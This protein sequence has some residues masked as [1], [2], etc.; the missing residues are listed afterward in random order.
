MSLDF[1][2]INP[3]L[4]FEKDRRYFDGL[5]VDEDV[6]RQNSPYVGIGYL[7]AIAKK[8]KIKARYI[9]MTHGVSL[10][11]VLDYIDKQKPS[12]IG[13][14]AF[15]TKIKSAGEIARK[16]KEKYPKV[17]VCIGGSHAT[18]MPRETLEEFKGFD[19]VIRGEAENSI[20]Q[21]FRKPLSEVRGIVTR[22][23][24]VM[25]YDRI[26]DLDELPFP[27]WEEFD[28]TKYPGSD[29]HQTNLELPINTSR[30]C[31][32]K[33]VFCARPFGRKRIHRSIDSVIGEVERNISDFNAQAIYFCDETFIADPDYSEKLFR[34]MIE[35]GINKKIRW[36]C[37]TRVDNIN[38]DLFKLIKKA[39]CYYV[40]IGF[41]SADDEILKKAGKEINV[42]QIKNTVD[43]VK[44]AG[45]ICTG[46]FILGLPG[47]TRETVNKSIKLAQELDIYSTTFPIAVPFPGTALRKMAEKNMYGLR[48]LSNNWD[49]YGKQY[50]GVM[51]S[52]SLSIEELRRLQ[53]TAYSVIPKKKMP[54][55]KRL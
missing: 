41:E 48:I 9:D 10:D 37:E 3:S 24:T 52:E 34:K 12:V 31:F 5:K 50:P 16:I 32:G 11:N 55:L 18:A 42:S 29:P 22:E 14:T 7:L 44:R 15:T 25:G 51:E 40:F 4:D 23:S 13:F 43:W 47:E 45:I 19:F 20:I 35:K 2:L 39:G 54:K 33:C 6:P 8:E 17:L 36:S 28:L 27:A 21:I 26:E 38:S 46:S 30:G 53:R 49:D 1:L